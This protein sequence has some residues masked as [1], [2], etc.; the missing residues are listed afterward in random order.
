MIR[1]FVMILCVFVLSSVCVFGD[2]GTSLMNFENA[3]VTIE[4]EHELLGGE[5][6]NAP[7][8]FVLQAITKDAPMPA[9]AKD[10]EKVI[11]IKPGEKF[12]FGSIQYSTYGTYDYLIKRNI[13]PSENMKYDE[14]TYTVHV[15]VMADGSVVMI[16]ENN[17]TKTKVDTIKYTDTYTP[18]TT[19]E[20]PKDPQK[21]EDPL[22]TVEKEQPPKQ[23]PPTSSEVSKEPVKRSGYKTGDILPFV[24]GGVLIILV[25]SI[26]AVLYRRK[27]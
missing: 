21:P 12:T 8:S 1:K 20:K 25:I 3:S 17:I 11:D 9:D 14:T 15:S 27:K 4:G 19:P 6:N 24:L 5:V 23:D 10:G 18:V 2:A 16:I 22:T 7:L 26:A 13:V